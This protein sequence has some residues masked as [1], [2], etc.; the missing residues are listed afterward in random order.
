MAAISLALIPP[1]LSSCKK[2]DLVNSE[3]SSSSDLGS[4]ATKNGDQKNPI[5]KSMY[6]NYIVVSNHTLSKDQKLTNKFACAE[7]LDCSMV[8]MIK[9][10]ERSISQKLFDK[11]VIVG[12]Y[13]PKK[14]DK[15]VTYKIYNQNLEYVVTD[16]LTQPNIKFPIGSGG[17]FKNSLQSKIVSLNEAEKYLPKEVVDFLT[18]TKVS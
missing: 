5:A 8:K 13:L 3:S 9:V 7:V 17:N 10:K 4:L 12:N 11:P 15:K 14:G 16:F 2:D 1:I 6:F 18:Y